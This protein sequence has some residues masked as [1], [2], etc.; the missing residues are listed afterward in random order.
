MRRRH[1]TEFK[2]RDG[3]EAMNEEKTTALLL[4]A[5]LFLGIASVPAQAF[6][7]HSLTPE[8]GARL[9]I[10]LR[11]NDDLQAQFL[12]DV[13]G[14]LEAW[15]SLADWQREALRNLPQKNLEAAAQAALACRENGLA[16][17][18]QELKK[19]E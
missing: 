9:Y 15:F 6:E 16:V 7:K 11:Q 17:F 3:L 18:F 2:A 4:V 12:A 14:F 5:A 1:D 13:K 10:E 19:Q 8:E